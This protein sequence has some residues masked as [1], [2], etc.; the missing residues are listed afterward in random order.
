MSR[1]DKRHF[2]VDCPLYRKM[3]VQ[4]RISLLE[5]A[6]ICKKC[7]NHKRR[8][9][10]GAKRCAKR[11]EENHW[12]CREFSDPAE[13]GTPQKRLP[14]VQHQPG[15]LVYGC[16][17]EIHVR[18]R[19]DME[20]GGYNVRLTTLYDS[21]QKQSYIRDEVARRHTLRYIRVPERTVKLS[22]ATKEKAT[23]LYILDVR[24][25]S[26]AMKEPEVVTCYG[27]EGG[28]RT[29]PEEFGANELRHKF[30]KRPGRLTNSNVAQP[31]ADM[32]LLVGADNPYLMPTVI[33]QSVTHGTDL[34]VTRNPLY[35]GEMLAGE[36]SGTAW[37]KKGAAGGG[38]EK[39]STPKQRQQQ[40]S[41]RPV[42]APPVQTPAAASEWQEGSE[43]QPAAGPSGV[44]SGR[45]LDSSPALSVAAS[46]TM[47]SAEERA[48]SSP[49]AR[50][51]S[52]EKSSSEE[53]RLPCAR[54]SRARLESSASETSAASP[55]RVAHGD[56]SSVSR[57]PPWK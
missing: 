5:A 42:K 31:E 29:L 36:T 45:R 35:I 49:P 51:S 14:A 34:F 4:H 41:K 27:V 1:C 13:G 46:D 7:L 32:E 38:K 19:A 24:P 21:N 8:D 56:G 2:P 37:T 44:R 52:R 30:A 43:E 25:R 12:M 50:D 22:P 39:T 55:G 23:K 16:R 40:A 11:H 57:G 48:A 54:K 18:S 28:Q 33:Y 47:V 26:R 20:A 17:T 9:D 6:G 10:R 53:P 3:P 15:R